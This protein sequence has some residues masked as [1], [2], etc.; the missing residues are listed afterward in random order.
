MVDGINE[1]TSFV[2]LETDAKDGELAEIVAVIWRKQPWR[3]QIMK[4]KVFDD[5]VPSEGMST[6]TKN[7]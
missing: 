5:F 6:N 7:N 3:K 4:L 2:N 1:Y